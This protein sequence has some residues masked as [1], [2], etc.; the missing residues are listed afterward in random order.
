LPALLAAPAVLVSL[1]CAAQ[2]WQ[3]SRNIEF[4]VPSGA[5]AALDTAAREL[6][7]ALERQKIV[8]RPMLVSNRSGG[9]GAIAIQALQQHPGDGHWLSTF[10]TGM[11]NARAIG[12]VSAT[13]EE[14]TPIAVLLEEAV[15]VAVRADSPMKN[16]SDLVVKLKASPDSLSIGVATAVGNHIHAGMAK[17]LK[18]AGVDIARLRVVPYKSSAESMTALLGGHLDVIAA[19]TP[20]VIVQMQ[21]GKIRVLA[22]ATAERLPGALAGVSTWTEQ[23]IPAVYS[24]VQGVLGPKG[25]THEQ[26]KFWENAFRKVSGTQEWKDFL[27][28][29]NWR[30]VFMD[31]AETTRYMATEYTAAKALIGELKLDTK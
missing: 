30:P 1:P 14:L 5:G 24:S 27:A 6:V 17:P 15:V 12:S 9:A 2:E 29:Q 19:T 23:G 11:I 28:R 7:N 25:L 13:Y 3:P 26:V 10:T 4:V 21:T 18:V 16:A 8:D 20:N 22:V 31:S